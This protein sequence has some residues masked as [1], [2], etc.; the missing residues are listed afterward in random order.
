V[1]RVGGRAAHGL[2][3]PGV[4][5]ASRARDAPASLDVGVTITPS[6]TRTTR[7]RPRRRGRPPRASWLSTGYQ[8]LATDLAGDSATAAAP[9][10]RRPPPTTSPA[11]V[12]LLLP[13]QQRF[14]GLPVPGLL[15]LSLLQ[16]CVPPRPRIPQPLYAHGRRHLGARPHRMR[17]E[18]CLLRGPL[19]A[20]RLRHLPRL[21]HQPASQN[22]YNHRV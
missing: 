14:H 18:R 2:G 16:P 10:P 22:F 13:H 5:A 12:C 19:G 20:L 3:R 11:R 21:R 17:G 1:R 4:G 8:P 7:P 9:S 6:P 15:L